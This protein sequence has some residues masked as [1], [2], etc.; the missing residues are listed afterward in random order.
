MLADLARSLDPSRIAADVG[1]TLDPWQRDLMR[2]DAKRVLMLC[3]RQSGKSTVAALIANSTVLQQPGSLVLLL[4]PSQRQ[5]S[6]QF[7]TVMAYAR[8]VTDA[9]AMRP[10]ANLWSR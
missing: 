5:S 4:S 10:P 3:S 9:P 2:S 8:Q 1:L 7:R 6:E